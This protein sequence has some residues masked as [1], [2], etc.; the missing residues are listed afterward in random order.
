MLAQAVAASVPGMLQAPPAPMPG[1]TMTRLPP[2]N[3]Q[4][5]QQPQQVLPVKLPDS[6]PT[7]PTPGAAFP[8]A[9]NLPQTGNP[10]FDMLGPIV[11]RYL[12]LL[13]QKA[14][15]ESVAGLYAEVILDSTPEGAVEPILEYP[16]SD[17]VDYLATLH[18]PVNDERPWFVSLID[19]MRLMLEEEPTPPDIGELV[20][21][22]AAPS[23]TEG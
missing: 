20:A 16:T 8:T 11:V 5:P 7:P 21:T 1:V 14:Q 23:S 10:A 12:P 19:E 22:S 2:P 15:S 9:F 4:H 13:V 18:P 6:P 17:I 3:F